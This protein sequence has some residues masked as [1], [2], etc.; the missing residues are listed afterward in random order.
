MSLFQ[1]EK[2][3]IVFLGLMAFAYKNFDIPVE[4]PEPGGAIT[5]HKG[6]NIFASIV[7]N[8]DGEII[9]LK[10]NCI[11]SQNNPMLHAEQLTLKESIERINEKRPRDE[12]TTSVEKYYRE[13]LFNA[14]DQAG[15]F[16]VGGTIYTTLEPCPFC[17]SALLV[18][19][20]KRIVYI[21]PDSS[22]GGAFFFLKEG[23]YAKYDMAYAQLDIRPHGN[24]VLINFAAGAHKS[25]LNYIKTK[26][27]QIPT[28][29][30]DSLFEDLK[31]YSNFFLLLT[32]QDLHTEGEERACNLRT[33]TDLQKRVEMSKPA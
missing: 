24:S 33:L 1:S 19:R 25:I 28:L 8:A 10:A 5:H 32:E 14:P 12:K 22:Y 31:K 18:T 15:N 26:P 7:D 3:A 11:H 20:M 23:F 27:D 29:Y 30:L 9:G 16:K 17:T 21:I 13:L 6:L 4:S 2:D